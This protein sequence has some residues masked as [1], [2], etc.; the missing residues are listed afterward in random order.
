M[1]R[2]AGGAD[3]GGPGHTQFRQDRLKRAPDGPA[4]SPVFQRGQTVRALC[5]TLRLSLSKAHC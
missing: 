1:G 5:P 4:N 3:A 2:R